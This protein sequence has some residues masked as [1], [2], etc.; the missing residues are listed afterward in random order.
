MKWKN[1]SKS[2]AQQLFINWTNNNVV[3][4]FNGES[5]YEDLHSELVTIHRNVTI[6]IEESNLKG[7]IKYFYDLHFGLDLYMLM[8]D[9]YKL[10]VRD[11]SNDEIWIYISMNV[12]PHIVEERWG[13]AETRFFKE[14]RR[15]WLKTI[16]WYIHLSWNGSKESTLQI[17]SSLTTDEILQ[18][19]E[20]PGPYGYR[21]SF[22]R[23]LMR[24]FNEIDIENKNRGLFRKIIIFNTARVRMVE[25]SLY[26]GGIEKY[27]GELITYFEN[28][29]QRA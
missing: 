2:N 27:V 4:Q 3:R 23:E 16:W 24:Q 18:L 6:K 29:L 8:K 14:S 5:I 7:S 12:I 20:R 26:P 17:L 13:L 25:P 1:L 28:T 11:A 15:I 10:T 21:V 19:V 22:T 9:K